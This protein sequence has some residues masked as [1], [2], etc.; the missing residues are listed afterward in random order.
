[1]DG[2]G[3]IYQVEQRTKMKEILNPVRLLTVKE[4]IKLGA[5]YAKNISDAA[6]HHVIGE[7]TSKVC[8]INVMHRWESLLSQQL[9][10][11]MFVCEKPSLMEY[12]VGTDGYSHEIT[13]TSYEDDLEEA[14]SK[15]LFEGFEKS[16][17]LDVLTFKNIIDYDYGCEVLNVAYDQEDLKQVAD[18]TIHD[19][20]VEID[21]YNRTAKEKILLNWTDNAIKY[22]TES[23]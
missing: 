11:E 12:Y 2:N 7:I 6:H 13:G 20:I 1:M 14:S 17:I 5:E 8:A 21:R 23:K 10:K 18:P 19:L 15:V 22:L 4:W 16:H 9:K 3:W